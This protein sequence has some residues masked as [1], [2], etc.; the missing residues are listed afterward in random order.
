[1]LQM[2]HRNVRSCLLSPETRP[3]WIVLVLVANENEG[4]ERE[5]I[6]M[7]SGCCVYERASAFVLTCI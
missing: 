5:A 7:P 4:A 2:Q 6:K 3:E 1:M